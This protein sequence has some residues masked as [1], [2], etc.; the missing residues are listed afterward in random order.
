MAPPKTDYALL[1][2]ARHPAVSA[3]RARVDVVLLDLPAARIPRW[4]GAAGTRLHFPAAHHDRIRMGTEQRHADGGNQ[5]LVA[6]DR[7]DRRSGRAGRRRASPIAA[8]SPAAVRIGTDGRS[9]RNE[10]LGNEDVA[11]GDV[12]Y[13]SSVI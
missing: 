9:Q 2:S 1:P 3:R 10:H 6:A 12:G 11:A 5:S 4:P 7:G 8:L 13:V